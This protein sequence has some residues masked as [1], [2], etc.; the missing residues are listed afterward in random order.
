MA[1]RRRSTLV[2]GIVS[3]TFIAPDAW[4]TFPTSGIGRFVTATCK[5][6]MG[7][8]AE[9]RQSGDLYMKV[10]VAGDWAHYSRRDV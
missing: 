6:G 4:P 8:E 3:M 9:W 5:T 1:A 7:P 10:A 2:M